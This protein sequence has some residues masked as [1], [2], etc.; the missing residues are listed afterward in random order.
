MLLLQIL[1][2]LF[3][4]TLLLLSLVLLLLL[5][6]LLLQ[7]NLLLQLPLPSI[8]FCFSLP[9]SV[10]LDLFC[11]FEGSFDTSTQY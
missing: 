8:I 5:L 9:I 7:L 1:L 10:L 2:L 11:P 3:L 6:S 4:S